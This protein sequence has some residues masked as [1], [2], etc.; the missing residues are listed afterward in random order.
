MWAEHR[1][2]T[3]NLGA[4]PHTTQLPWRPRSEALAVNDRGPGLIVLALRDPHLL[5]GT[6]RGQDGASNPHRV[7]PLGWCNH[8]DFHGGWRKGCELLG[9]PLANAGEHGGTP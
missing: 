3:V 2:A 5:E 6:Q 4:H 9:H 8:F 7:L 1:A